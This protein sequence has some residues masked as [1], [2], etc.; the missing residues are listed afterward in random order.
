[1]PYLINSTSCSKSII[2]R[3]DIDAYMSWLIMNDY[4][5]ITLLLLI[6]YHR[7]MAG[8][9]TGINVRWGAFHIY[10]DVSPENGPK[11]SNFPQKSIKK[12]GRKRPTGKLGLPTANGNL[13][14]SAVIVII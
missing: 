2:V 5:I 7:L 13:P 10:Q 9:N 1:M 14:F 11:K 3:G 4:A 6:N 12:M 8:T